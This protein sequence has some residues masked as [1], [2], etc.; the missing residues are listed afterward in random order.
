MRLTLLTLLAVLTAAAPAAADSVVVRF[1]TATP[2]TAAQR[3][4][5]AAGA[6]AAQAG[7]G[8]ASVVRLGHGIDADRAVRRLAA[9]RGVAWAAPEYRARVAAYNDTGVAAR[10]GAA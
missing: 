3:T 6:V 2:A 9:D 4:L 7:P 5:R 10:T 8:G 1:K